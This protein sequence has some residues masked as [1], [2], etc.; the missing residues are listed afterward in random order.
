MI[1]FDHSRLV[2]IFFYRVSSSL[3]VSI[4]LKMGKSCVLIGYMSGQHGP[5][6]PHGFVRFDPAQEKNCVEQTYRSKSV[7]DRNNVKQ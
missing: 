2:T 5:I 3:M 1:V 4:L 7:R 6:F